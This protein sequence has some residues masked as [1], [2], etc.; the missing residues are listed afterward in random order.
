MNWTAMLFISLPV[1][2]KDIRCKCH[3]AS[4]KCSRSPD[5][6]DRDGVSL[7]LMPCPAGEGV[8]VENST[9]TSGLTEILL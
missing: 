7:T 1:L 6:R 3:Q 8:L 4:A 2:L 9:R 5:T